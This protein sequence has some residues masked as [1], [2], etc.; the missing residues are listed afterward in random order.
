MTLVLYLIG[1]SRWR[2]QL[3]ARLPR[4]RKRRG[5]TPIASGMVRPLFG[6]QVFHGDFTILTIS[7]VDLGGFSMGFNLTYGHQQWDFS[8][9]FLGF[10][11][12]QGSFVGFSWDCFNWDF[13]WWFMGIEATSFCGY[14]WLIYP[15]S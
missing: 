15:H 1:N 10:H 7:M 3:G 13:F 6:A 4:L 5:R 2:R 8:D 12:Q 11:N 9:F 14:Q